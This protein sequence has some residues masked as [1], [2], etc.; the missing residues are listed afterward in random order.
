MYGKK[1]DL[2]AAVLH[3][4][5]SKIESDTDLQL[6]VDVLVRQEGSTLKAQRDLTLDAGQL[7]NKGL[8]QAA[9][10]SSVHS[11]RVDNR[12]TGRVLAG[13]QAKLHSKTLNNAGLIDGQM[14]QL[15]AGDVVNTGKIYGD[16][17]AI[18]A[19]SLRNDKHGAT[20][21]VSAARGDLDLVVAALVNREHALIY[22]GG[23]YDWAGS[24]IQRAAHKARPAQLR[25]LRRR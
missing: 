22:V 21:G 11:D 18:Q 23:T 1:V 12:Q 20:A 16:A 19:N 6:R 24:W 9:Q 15:V 4:S 3:V 14:T 10:D 17:I 5:D 13:A 25:I 7:D 8:I 2:Q